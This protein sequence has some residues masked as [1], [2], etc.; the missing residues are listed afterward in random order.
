MKKFFGFIFAYLALLLFISPQKVLAYTFPGSGDGTIEHPYQINTCLD[1]QAVKDYLT[2]NFIVNNDVYCGALDKNGNDNGINN[3]NLWSD[4]N[5]SGLL[6]IG[7]WAN[8]FIGTFDG[9]NKKI[10]GLHINRGVGATGINV[11]LFGVI[12]AGEAGSVQVKDISLV[13]ADVSGWVDIGSLAGG[14]SGR[15]ERVSAT[16]TVAG[17]SNTGGLVGQHVESSNVDNNSSPLVYTWNGSKYTYVADVGR[18]VNRDTSGLDLAQIDSYNLAPKGDKYSM[19]IGE[20]YNE[21]VYYDELALMTFDHVP[22]YSV[23]SP[24]DRVV[25]ESDLRT[26]SNTPTNP[27]LSCA[28]M[29]G[30]NCLDSLKSY[31][32]KWGY[33]DKSLVNSW[34]MDF[35][36]LSNK[37]NIQL[38]MRGAR[39]YAAQVA[40]ERDNTYNPMRNIEVKDTNGNWVAIYTKKDLYSNG[41]PRLRTINLTGKF[42]TNDY[43]VRVSLDTWNINYFAV[44]TSEQVP[45]TMHKYYPTKADLGFRGFSEIDKTYYNN[46]IFDKVSSVPTGFFANQWGNFTKYGDVSPLLQSTNDQF[47]VMRYGDNMDVE[48]PYVA[49]PN[50]MERSFILYNNVLYKHAVNDNIGSLGKTV[51]PLPYQGMPPYSKDT[52]YPMTPDNI[53]YL[54]IWNTRHY[55]GI[56]N[57]GGSTIVDSYTNVEVTGTNNNVGGLVGYNTKDI[58][59]SYALGRVNAEGI[60]YVGG[61]VG[62]NQGTG[63]NIQSSYATGDVTGVNYVGGLVGYNQSGDIQSSYA[64]GAVTANSIAGGL[65][66][67]NRSNITKSFA[68]GNVTVADMEAGG[69]VGYN[70]SG[71]IDQSYAAGTIS[72]PNE[73]GGFAGKNNGEIRDCY[74]TSIVLDTVN[75]NNTTTKF[76][77]FVGNL[78]G[79]LMLRSYSSGSVTSDGVSSFMGGFFGGNMS[80]EIRDSFTI[81]QLVPNSESVSRGIVG[82]F[83]GNIATF[84]DDWYMDYG[85]SYNCYGGTSADGC[86]AISQV[87]YP[88]Y[89]ESNSTNSPFRSQTDGPVQV[90]DFTDVWKVNTGAL[91]TLRG[92]V[93]LSDDNIT[94]TPTPS[95]SQQSSSTP[96]NNSSSSSGAPT[97]GDSKPVSSPDVFQAN[98]APKSA[99]IFFTPLSDTNTYFISF[100]TNP[101]AEEHGATA[102]LA[103]EGVQNFT[104]NLLKQNTVYY[105]KVRGQNGCMPGDWSNVMKIKTNSQIYY[106]NI[107]TSFVSTISNILNPTKPELQTTSKSTTTSPEL[108]ITKAAE[109]TKNQSNSSTQ[110]PKKN[111]CFLFLCW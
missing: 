16:G 27:L 66:G 88:H 77:G 37:D 69:F 10:I 25:K 54:K 81:S 60:A 94:P 4:S 12:D 84:I 80:G 17:G 62:L 75:S 32:D 50:G 98:T 109:P 36:D 13:D 15:V 83:G 34:T 11:G 106:K 46:H 82:N 104:I 53:D 91:P 47:V 103:H 57:P 21:I 92:V 87:S 3:T 28:D 29:Y 19:K 2:D 93:V 99:K 8:R 48:F 9:N 100:S 6:P 58:I 76:G 95:S 39:D 20:E 63:Y 1:L 70:L 105:I 85:N 74:T 31:D 5:G 78:E 22:G 72:G 56:A 41:T 64:T 90:W 111:T 86:S 65:V 42:L 38:I 97:C 68:S 44:D 43:H 110:A 7:N 67:V 79:G 49:P 30:N 52:Q 96:A 61:L 71:I 55:N 40:Q 23:V 89:F 14:L 107:F 101:N 108:V 18:L 33:T 51:D 59:R 26:V 24:L 73:I 35:G 102:T 45:V